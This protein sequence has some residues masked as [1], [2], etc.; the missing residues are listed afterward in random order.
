M[1]EQSASGP[2]AAEFA[3]LVK[4][5][6]GAAYPAWLLFNT[7]GWLIN[8]RTNV[9]AFAYAVQ[10]MPAGSAI[11][12]IGT[13][14]GQSV[15]MLTYLL[16]KY[17]REAA[18]FCC[19]PY[20]FEGTEAPIGGFFDAGSSAYRDYCLETVRRNLQTFSNHCLPHL[21]E[22]GSH[23]FL[24]AWAAREERHDVFG[25]PARL[26]GPLGLVYI[27]GAHAYEAVK[28]DFEGADPFIAPGGF[29][30]FDDSTPDWPGVH[31]VVQ[32]V[33]RRPDYELVFNPPNYF[34]RKRAR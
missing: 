27:D 17:R 3:R 23:D 33:L 15:C 30:L 22:A 14:L 20:D 24:A 6:E 8:A 2:N 21:V 19:D 10:N 9:V 26:G 34:F 11:L 29:V 1:V 5:M 12:E 13:Y 18:V 31:R 7:G 25:R 28:G 16:W 4:E 32:E